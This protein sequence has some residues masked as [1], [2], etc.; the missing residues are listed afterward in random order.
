MTKRREVRVTDPFFEELDGQLR[1]ERG[2]GA[3]PSATDFLILEL[4]AI[5]ERFA[6]D[7][8]NLAEAVAGVPGIRMFIGTSVLV[9][10][11]VVH[12]VETVDGVVELVG[13]E[14]DV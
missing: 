2:P 5:V 11:F 9:R 13:V 6:S 12:G 3:E 8:Q 4:P 1:R 10:A 14:L 7:F